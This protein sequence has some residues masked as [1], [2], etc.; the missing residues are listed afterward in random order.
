MQK[1]DA[2]AKRRVECP[3]APLPAWVR[4][5]TRVWFHETERVIGDVD[6]RGLVLHTY[7]R[8]YLPSSRLLNPN[9]LA[10][11]LDTGALR[12]FSVSAHGN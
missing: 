6:E 1:F 9:E 7:R 4:T 11:A 2:M 8:G 12:P 3:D 5:G 10:A